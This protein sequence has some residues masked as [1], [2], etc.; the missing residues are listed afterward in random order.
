MPGF[1][2]ADPGTNIV[3]DGGLYNRLMDAIERAANLTVGGDLEML[4]TA[5]GRCIWH[6]P[7]SSPG[8]SPVRLVQT[9]GSAGSSSAYC[10]YTY[11]VKDTTNTITLG[12]NVAVTFA[13]PF[14]AQCITAATYGVAYYDSTGAIKILS[15]DE[16]FKTTNC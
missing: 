13:R 4:D 8:L 11:T 9:G 15:C 12:T 10:T 16:V 6:A 1:P 3:L 14:K 5:S 7:S 2:R